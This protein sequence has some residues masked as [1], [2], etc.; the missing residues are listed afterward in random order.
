MYGLGWD[1]VGAS[2]SVAV[3]TGSVAYRPRAGLICLLL[4]WFG[5]LLLTMPEGPEMLGVSQN[6]SGSL[7]GL[8]LGRARPRGAL[9]AP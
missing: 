2:R 6:P 3:K 7:S 4:R 9:S 8:S 5:L 1:V